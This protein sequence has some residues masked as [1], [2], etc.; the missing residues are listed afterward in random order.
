MI[1]TGNP[2]K[3]NITPQTDDGHLP[4]LIYANGGACPRPVPPPPPKFRSKSEN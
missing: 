1:Q 4:D 2:L 3:T